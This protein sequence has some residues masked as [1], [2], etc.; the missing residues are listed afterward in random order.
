VKLTKAIQL[1]EAPPVPELPPA[2]A[3]AYEFRETNGVHTPHD[4]NAIRLATGGPATLYTMPQFEVR[5]QDGT[6]WTARTGR[7]DFSGISP[8]GVEV[9]GGVVCFLLRSID[10]RITR[11]NAEAHLA[12]FTPALQEEVRLWMQ[13]QRER[14]Q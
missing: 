9:V 13:E 12:G 3:P 4:A 10:G 7:R 11:F 5:A 1:Y 6:V 2:A 14:A 8:I